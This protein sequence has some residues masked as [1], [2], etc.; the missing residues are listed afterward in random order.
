MLSKKSKTD[1]YRRSVDEM[2]LQRTVPAILIS[3]LL[4]LAAPAKVFILA[5]QSNMT[6]SGK[7]HDLDSFDLPSEFQIFRTIEGYAP[8]QDDW[9]MMTKTNTHIETWVPQ[10][11]GPEM[12]LAESLADE[13]PGE[14]I[15][16]IKTAYGGTSLAESW[17]PGNRV[18]DSTFLETVNKARSKLDDHN[19]S[20]RL[21]GFFWMQG[22]AD[23]G[24]LKIAQAYKENLKAFVKNIRKDLKAPNLPFIYGKIANNVDSSNHQPIWAFGSIVQKAQREAQSEIPNSV[25][26]KKTALEAVWPGGLN[27]LA[28]FNSQGI[29]SVGRDF[30]EAW[31]A[32]DR[33]RSRPFRDNQESD[34][35]DAL[36]PPSQ[37][38]PRSL[39]MIAPQHPSLAIRWSTAS[40]HTGTL[41]ASEIVQR[42]AALRGQT[43]FLQARLPDGRLWQGTHVVP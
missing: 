18:Y 37:Q 38:A 16:F 35:S 34:A 25:F 14:T 7:V 17:Q 9:L 6:G 11:F 41:A 40:G 19:I 29:L 10:R 28:H 36:I 22:E 23:A 31:I 43:V 3:A 26:V 15:Y 1:K 20:Y 24:A 13:Y 30:G 8:L 32:Y 21:A 4:T 2:L 33:A 27:E 39:A 5:G 42:P 12:G